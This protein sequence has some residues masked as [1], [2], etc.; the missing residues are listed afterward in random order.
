MGKQ[1][2]ITN[3]WD[4]ATSG[5][6]ISQ[7]LPQA[8][9]KALTRAGLPIENKNDPRLVIN[10]DAMRVAPAIYE[11]NV[12]L[13]ADDNYFRTKAKSTEGK[14]TAAMEAEAE[15]LM[16]LYNN[17]PKEIREAS[18]DWYLGANKTSQE[19]AKKYDVSNETSAGVIASLSP[20]MDW[21]KNVSLANRVLSIHRQAQ[22]KSLPKDAHKEL[23]NIYQQIVKKKTDPLFG[24]KNTKYDDDI[25]IIQS[26]VP[27]N[28]LTTNQKAMYVRAMDK[29]YNSP[30]YYL[31]DPTGNIVGQALTKD[32]K[33]AKM[34]W[35]SNT[36]IG[37]AINVI[38]NPTPEGISSQMGDAHK[39]RN[40]YN[41][42]VDPRYAL[43][44]PFVGDVTIDTHAVAASM[45]KPL[46]GQSSAVKANFGSGGGA[47][48]TNLTGARGTYGLHADAARMAAKEAGIMPREMQSI[49]WD[50]ARTM[51]PRTFK[52]PENVQAVENIWDMHKKG[53]ITANDARDAIVEKSGGFGTADW[54][55]AGS[56]N[57][58][59]VAGGSAAGAGGILA[60]DALANDFLGGSGGGTPSI[61][62]A[63]STELL[64]RRV[65]QPGILAQD[66][67]GDLMGGM[68]FSKVNSE[69]R[70]FLP[71]IAEYAK[72][73]LRGAATGSLDTADS[74]RG[75]G[76]KMGFIPDTSEYMPDAAREQARQSTRDRIPEG[77]R[78]Y[79]SDGEDDFFK[80]VGAFFGL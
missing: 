52:T 66:Y 57:R 10:Q 30:D 5:Q 41:N 35:G 37:K 43:N 2:I 39:V 76:E 20:Q 38:E 32:G 17:A 18:R 27:F 78:K 74:I 49:T 15:N 1:A 73:M 11:K 22:G 24:K 48:S 50:T 4:L 77:E 3:L 62:P 53:R 55:T 23:N 70:P 51:F 45:M 68:D 8:K 54:S 59:N 71:T 14:A 21:N 80:K 36:E 46:S 65:E 6:R 47:G 34:G 33:P 61:N 44:N 67:E 69:Q 28:E 40:F 56:N 25:K 58:K 19:L 60:T 31:S 13:L 63:I 64:G 16:W 79:T 9:E 72:S 42:I 12:G 7:R 29:T 26:G 75:L